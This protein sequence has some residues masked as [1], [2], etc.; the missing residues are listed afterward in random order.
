MLPRSEKKYKSGLPYRNARQH[1]EECLGEVLKLIPDKS[2]IVL[3]QAS[4]HKRITEETKNPTTAFRKQEI[5][6]WLTAH[7]I[8]LPNGFSEFSKM[9][10]PMLLA[11]ARQNKMT[12]LYVVEKM[13]RDSG[14][15][16]KLLWLPVA[17]CAIS[18]NP[19]SSCCDH[20]QKL[21]SLLVER[22]KVV[23]TFVSDRL[24]A[25]E[26]IINFGDDDSNP[27]EDDQIYSHP[28][29]IQ[30]VMADACNNENAE[31]MHS[32]S[33][34][35]QKMKIS[36]VKV[37][38][39]TERRRVNPDRLEMLI[40]ML[41]LKTKQTRAQIGMLIRRRGQT[42]TKLWAMKNRE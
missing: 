35:T 30:D 39:A 1:Y 32:E 28:A 41:Q 29:D 42:K 38:T 2:V 18:Q 21:E 23:D 7:D 16:V 6:D 8:P 20:V 37:L 26:I 36:T 31:S 24:A 15:D 27:E 14:K 19:W 22:E 10:V 17:H 34:A 13:A 11:L 25:N 9:T 33:L 4:Y 12:P 3:D 5:I 40:S